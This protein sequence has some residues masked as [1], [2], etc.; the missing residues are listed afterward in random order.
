LKCIV[1]RITHSCELAPKGLFKISEENPTQID[2]ED[3]FK[4]PEV[5]EMGVL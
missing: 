3:E 1:A 2:Y 4:T 5:N